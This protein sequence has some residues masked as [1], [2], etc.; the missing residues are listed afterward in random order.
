VLALWYSDFGQAPM[1]LDGRIAERRLRRAK[2]LA[3]TG[4]FVARLDDEIFRNM[5]RDQLEGVADRAWRRAHN[6]DDDAA[7]VPEMRLRVRCRDVAAMRSAVEPR[8][9]EYTKQWRAA[10]VATENDVHV[11][12]YFVQ[13]RKKTMADDL[14][15]LVRMVGSSEVIDAELV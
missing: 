7:T 13:L 10:A 9:K 6:A 15:V 3:R 2:Q 5:T 11:V 14:I 8:L 4:T 12:D 1:E